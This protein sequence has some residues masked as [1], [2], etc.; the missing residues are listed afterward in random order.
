MDSTE[1]TEGFP[2]DAKGVESAFLGYDEAVHIT[3]RRAAHPDARQC[4]H[5]PWQEVRS[6]HR[7]APMAALSLVITIPAEDLS[8][9][10]HCQAVPRP[11]YHS[12]HSDL[13]QRLHLLRNEAD[14]LIAVAEKP[15]Q[16]LTPGVN[17]ALN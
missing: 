10:C 16:A 6:F 11:Y 4:I 15:L 9:L 12:E 1:N 7:I 5:V 14:L 8:T 2:P 3:S 17:L 13:R